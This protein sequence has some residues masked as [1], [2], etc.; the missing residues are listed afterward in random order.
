MEKDNEFTIS[1]SSDC[2]TYCETDIIGYFNCPNC[3]KQQYYNGEAGDVYICNCNARITF[4][5]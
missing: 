1:I 4:E 2:A 5:E 3:D